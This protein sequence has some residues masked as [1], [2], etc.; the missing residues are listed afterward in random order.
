MLRDR[1]IVD[2][3]TGGGLLRSMDTIHRGGG[4]TW[5]GAV[6]DHGQT[7]SAVAPGKRAE[8]LYSVYRSQ[9]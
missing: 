2:R 9:T 8:R 7:V 5:I 6:I 1:L 4:R 3:G